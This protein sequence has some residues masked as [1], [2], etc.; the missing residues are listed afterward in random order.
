MVQ[1]DKAETMTRRG[2]AVAAAAIGGLLI[3]GSAFAADLKVL[4]SG[5]YTGAYQKVAPQV[6]AAT[7][8]KTTQEFGASMGASDSSIPN[9]LKRG[10]NADVVIMV[11]YALDDLIKAGLVLPQG[12][13]DLAKSSIAM[14]VRAGAPKPDI[15]T[16][17][18]FKATLLAAKSIAYSDSASGVYLVNELFP[19]LGVADQLKG[20][21]HMVA[22]PVMVG[23]PLA[24]GEYDIG[25]QQLSELRTVP[26]IDIV[27]VIPP[28]TQL[29]TLYSA[30]VVKASK[31][32]AEAQAVIRYLRSPAAA[33]VIRETGLEPIP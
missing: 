23:E 3:A 16:V 9:R 24:K 4:T 25:F 13:V 1:T 17:E 33:K 22:A 5:G 26:G 31:H 19:K 7:G 10:E 15:S 28:Q 8:N 29:I 21:L 11:G 2:W 20:K 14:A 30:G 27:G 18:A 32:P 6:D 12:R